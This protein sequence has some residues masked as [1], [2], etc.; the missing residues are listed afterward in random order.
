M[1]DAN[2]ASDTLNISLGRDKNIIVK[3]EG[4]KDVNDKKIIGNNIK[5]TLGWDI[6]I[7]NNK[8]TKVKVFVEDQYPISEKKSIEISLLESSKAKIEE[9]IGKLTWELQLEPNEKKLI[10]YKYSVK[11]PKE[12]NLTTE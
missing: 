11:Y 4:N 6:T 1:I 10:S 7:K 5:E 8:D 9:K 3:R 12:I 2:N